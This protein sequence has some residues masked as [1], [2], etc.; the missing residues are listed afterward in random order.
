MAD[1]SL[2]EVVPADRVR[3]VTARRMRAAVQEMPHV[4]LHRSVEV[5]ALLESRRALSEGTSW[6]GPRVTLT[7]L[8]ASVLGSSLREYPRINGRTEEGEMRLY[9]RINLGVAVAVGDG[10]VAPVIRDV[11]Q[12][13]P[14]EIAT[15]LSQLAERAQHNRLLPSDLSDITFTMTNLGSYGVEYFTPILNPP[16]MGIL[17]VGAITQAVRFIDGNPRE[18]HLLGLSLSFDHAS[19]DGAQAARF[20]EVVAR[21]IQSPAFP[22]TSIDGGQM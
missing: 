6:S 18:V 17:G 21:R 1:A 13:S 8:L 14:I 20:L 4:T 5:T 2:Y 3:R 9:H 19:L 22:Q 16:Q 15:E 7:A 12:K 10:L 11:D